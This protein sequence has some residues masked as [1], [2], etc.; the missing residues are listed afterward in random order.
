[1]FS[2]QQKIN[3]YRIM[4]SP[5]TIF[6][7]PPLCAV[8]TQ[9][10]LQDKESVIV[11]KET[12]EKL[13][14]RIHEN[15]IQ[16]EYLVVDVDN[17]TEPVHIFY[18]EVKML[19]FP[20]IKQWVPLQGAETTLS[21]AHNDIDF[22]INFIDGDVLKGKTMGFNSDSNG[23]YLFPT[24]GNDSFI[25]TFIPYCMIAS[26]QIGPK[27]GE[28]LVKNNIINEKQVDSALA[29]QK[30]RR[31]QPL[32]EYLKS[33]ALVSNEELEQALIHQKEIPNIKL[34]ELL[35]K[36]KILSEEQLA[37]AL[38]EQRKNKTMLL[39][40]IL[41][42]HG[43]ISHL[44]LQQCLA[45]KLGIPFVDITK[46]SID[47]SVLLRIPEKIAKQHK[48]MP[49]EIFNGKIVVAMDDP[50]KWKVLESLRFA[51]SGEIIPVMATEED[52]EN[53][54]RTNYIF[55]TDNYSEVADDENDDDEF[56]ESSEVA[57]NLIV[58]LTN[59]IIF[60]AYEQN[61]SDIHIESNPGKRK[62][63]VRFRKDGELHNYHAF[64]PR[65]RRSVI[66]RLKI[67]ANLN[68]S[69][70]RRP[71]DGKINFGRFSRLKIELRVVT[72][73]TTGGEEDVV[74][75][76]LASGEPIP[77]EEMQLNKD[78]ADCIKYVL[79][80]P[81]GLFLVCGPTGSGKTTLL[82]SL[83]KYLNTPDKK[84]WTVE[85][86]VEITQK[87]L[88]QVQ[89]KSG[90]ID[91]QTALRS[92]LRADPDVIMVGEMRDIETSN[93]C[94]EASLTG[95]LVLSTLH[96]NSAAESI[97]RLLEMGMDPFNFSD[98]LLGIVAQRL[99]RALCP[100]CKE[101]EKVLQSGIC[102]LLDEYIN[103]YEQA[104]IAE[105]LSE[106]KN[107]L[108][109]SWKG[110][111]ADEQGV[112]TIYNSKGCSTC[113]DSG[114][115]GRIGLQEMLMVSD[116]VRVAIYRKTAA[117]ELLKMSLLEGMTTLK[118]D[119]IDK[120]LQGLTDIQQVRKVCP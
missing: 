50:L 11:V 92:F 75:R 112:F 59:K 4:N 95:H 73:P 21:E 15:G 118:Q 76:V 33:N 29:E 43:R 62:T 64:S 63:S 3:D 69:E 94:I 115:H 53:A 60:D 79:D 27:V 102:K 44:Q 88:R 7:P 36:E 51:S 5:T 116:D 46:L 10:I 78:N 96:T 45:N 119:G 35:V 28:Q 101:E 12:G 105:N 93:M 74:I 91:F 107:K 47:E 14:G 109:E 1:M 58:R 84:I 67:M 90:F 37:L 71:Q 8:H 103:Q 16:A 68:V 49:L 56:D 70:R 108:L 26:H 87:G 6:A 2:T 61:V 18:N 100:D 55:E 86:P 40:D 9:S 41:V 66:G 80:N 17:K 104:G 98:A 13:S 38:E 19:S 117:K 65:L 81:H 22:C 120:I 113:N 25:Y 34:G 85:D 111:Y 32:G 97:V 57:N 20:K 82:H 83:L 48:I 54:I 106:R 52:I 114:Y 24:Q 72:M 89:V 31:N 77:L 23:F 30:E 42:N 110:K 39:G 99:V